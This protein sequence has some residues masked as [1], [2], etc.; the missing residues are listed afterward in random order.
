MK[1]AICDD[2]QEDIFQMKALL[3]GYDVR[4]Y[5][6][7]EELFADMEKNNIY[8][9]L[10]LLDIYIENSMSGID[11]AKKIEYR[12][13]MRISVSFLQAMTFIG[14]HMIFMRFNI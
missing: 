2:C 5:L 14:R 8:F 6:C 10:Y 9:D 12:I 7:A 3:K 13:G 11:L 1:I 4:S